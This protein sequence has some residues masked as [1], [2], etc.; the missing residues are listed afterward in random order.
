MSNYIFFYIKNFVDYNGG[1][2]YL[3]IYSNNT[4]EMIKTNI[5]NSITECIKK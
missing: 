2:I 3:E 1:V 5:N 4:I